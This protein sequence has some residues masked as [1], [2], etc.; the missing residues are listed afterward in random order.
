MFK[1]MSL[2]LKIILGSSITVALMV[3]LGFVSISSMDSLQ[4]TTKWVE[5]TH[6]V[7]ARM[8]NILSI[9]V[10]ME[11]GMRG[12]L[13]A[14]KEEFLDPY[15]AG[16]AAFSKE[17]KLLQE[18]VN[19]NPA[20]VE[21]LGEAEQVI[22]EW[23]SKI[24]EPTIGLR[25][26]IGQSKSMNHMAALVKEARGKTFFDKFR[27]QIDTFKQREV[28]LMN[29]R[30]QRAA[31]AEKA[32]ERNYELLN[33]NTQWVDH[34]HKVIAKANMILSHAVDMETGMRG[35]LLAGKDAFL[36]PYNGGK[37][38]FYND[39]ASLS[40]T[41]NDNPA[42]V[43]LLKETKETLTTWMKEV[44]EPTIKQRR[45]VLAGSMTMDD[46]ATLVGQARGKKYFDKFRQQIATFVGREEKLMK[47][48]TDAVL[49][50]RQKTEEN[51]KLIKQTKQWVEH[52]AKV[53]AQADEIVS[54]AVNMET[55]MRGYLLAGQDSFLEPYTQH[56][57][58]VRVNLN[59]LQKT[60]DDNPAQVALLDEVRETLDG[61]HKNAASPAIELRRVIGDAKTMDDMAA[62]IGEARGKVYFDK[63]R[64]QVAKFI[65]R[66][67]KLLG[68]RQ[69]DAK[70]MAASAH[71][72]ILGGIIAG[73]L[74]ALIASFVLV[75]S[76]T[77]PFKQ[78][79][80]GLK[81][82]SSQEL[83]DVKEKF[84]SV[85]SGLTSGS[86]QVAMTSMAMA[87]GASQ[88]ASGVEE[89]SSSIEEITSQTRLN[90]ENADKANSIANSTRNAAEKG[91]S[92]MKE[93]SETIGRISNSASETAKIVKTIEEIAF[94]TNLLAL[95]AA[96]EAARAGEAGKGFAVVAE[97]VRNLA[98]R[99]AEAAKNTASLIDE[100]L[101]S[102]E[103][104]VQASNA[105]DTILQEIFGS[106]SEVSNLI[107]DVSKSCSQQAQGIEQINSEISEIDRVVQSSASGTEE[108]SSQAEELKEAV[109]VMIEILEDRQ[110]DHKQVTK[111]KKSF[112]TPKSNPMSITH[113]AF[114]TPAPKKSAA[115]VQSLS[116]A[117]KAEIQTLT[118]TIIPLTED[119]LADF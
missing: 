72:M 93:M 26:K 42:Q 13:L 117:E 89:I 71:W 21:L 113:E 114:H 41:V 109:A 45:A 110:A 29:E 115:P 17:V 31:D 2:K 105:V 81:T 67:S 82:F 54:G 24:T 60:V 101:K 57:E 52:T 91:T 107:G 96:V 100:S 27:Q 7:I 94:Q 98:Q 43:K 64:G 47:K 102:S 75:K 38:S 34:T 80:Q 12:Y 118:A 85:I 51:K 70:T 63:F 15:K 97:E 84:K 46:I 1:N 99:S 39:I 25:R 50:A 68:Q 35:F 112:S 49:L 119:E 16:K 73:V 55:G 56:K 87:S 22:K 62:L 23:N 3:I 77:E 78:I 6:T 58:K 32:N 48:R 11:T 79:F 88:Q 83:D 92:A 20:Q 116:P 66:E 44:A 103:D 4:E 36:E 108:L 10:D 53:I 19:D 95:N 90:S 111:P 14:G 8:N 86:E 5:H 65:E 37:R 9:A 76:V 104:G 61:W 30:K 106:I 18:T 59:S 28:K 74:L 40:K 33:Q 69:Q